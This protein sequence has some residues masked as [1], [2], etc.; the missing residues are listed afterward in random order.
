MT[1]TLR[2]LMLAI[3]AAL[4]VAGSGTAYYGVLQRT[5]DYSQPRP[6]GSMRRAGDPVN[7]YFFIGGLAGMSVGAGLI[8]FAVLRPTNRN[9]D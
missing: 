8:G 3:G 9:D 6:R 4:F 2:R 1:I 7:P 5:P